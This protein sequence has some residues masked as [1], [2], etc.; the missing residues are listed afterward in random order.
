MQQRSEEWF[1]ARRFCLTASD[2]ASVIGRNKFKTSVSVLLEKLGISK[3]F[4]GNEATAHGQLYE[5]EAIDIYEARTGKHVLRPGI[6][7]HKTLKGVAGSPDGI[8]RDGILLEIKVGFVRSNYTC[9]YSSWVCS[10][11]CSW[12][13]TLGHRS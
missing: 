12:Y 13:C 4:G 3:A 5:D 1:E 10:W 7:Y 11:V 9:C 6:E 2:V 8:T